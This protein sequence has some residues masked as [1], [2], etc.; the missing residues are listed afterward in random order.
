MMKSRDASED[1]QAGSH[2]PKLSAAMAFGFAAGALLAKKPAAAIAAVATGLLTCFSLAR[3]STEEESDDGKVKTET[4]STTPAT[5][6]PKAADA[7]SSPG[8]VEPLP[9]LI[10][11]APV[12]DAGS[13]D[14]P[15]LISLPEITTAEA[16]PPP[17]DDLSPPA[18][19]ARHLHDQWLREIESVIARK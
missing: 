18:D 1:H 3:R 6:E 16:T 9:A 17:L 14:E 12:F 19:I 11:E 10:E 7:P 13:A 5:V 8:S 4:T 2:S 15:L